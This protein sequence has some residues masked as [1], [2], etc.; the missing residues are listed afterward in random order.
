MR[1]GIFA[2]SFDP[3]TL[4]HLYITKTACEIFDK[5][6]ICIATNPSKNR[7]FSKESMQDGIEKTLINRGIKN[8][9]VI[10][11]PYYI[12]S[13]K[14]LGENKYFIVRGL[15]NAHDLNYEFNL[16]EEFFK[17][18][19]LDTIYLGSGEPQGIIPGTCSTK[20]RDCVKKGESISLYVPYE[21]EDI[22]NNYD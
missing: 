18:Y 1:I 7:M 16:S 6:I 2:G 14:E 17:K 9:Q 13:S 20:V 11:S 22:I 15:R 4:G 3:Y 21:I 5:V 12:P 8:F 19:G 10:C